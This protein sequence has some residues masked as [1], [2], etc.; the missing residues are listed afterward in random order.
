MYPAVSNAYYPQQQ[1]M[2]HDFKQQSAGSTMYN[3]VPM[4]SLAS[5]QQGNGIQ[6]PI[7]LHQQPTGQIRYAFPSRSLPT[8]PILSSDGQCMP[9]RHTSHHHRRTFEILHCSSRSIDLMAWH[10]SSTIISI[11]NQRILICIHLLRILILNKQATFN[12]VLFNHCSPT[13]S[14]LSSL[15]CLAP[16]FVMPSNDSAAIHYATNQL[17][18][19]NLQS[20]PDNSVKSFVSNG[21]NS[22]A[23]HHHHQYH[24]QHHH[25]HHR[26]ARQTRPLNTYHIDKTVPPMENELKS[27][28]P[29]LLP[30]SN[31][32][33]D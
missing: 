12:Q 2:S 21:M 22:S 17:A 1:S 27:T 7:L 6:L 16:S 30:G 28:D 9:V 25:H 10:P 11:L 3:Y 8:A 18:A 20:Q 14:Y 33:K 32:E 31:I 15:L 13:F 4:V 5:Y 26:Q 19:M 23:N 24:H 29:T